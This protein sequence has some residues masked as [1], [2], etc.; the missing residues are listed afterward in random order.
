MTELICHLGALLA[1]VHGA[2]G[3]EVRLGV[4]AV[5]DE[6]AAGRGLEVHHRPAVLHLLRQPPGL[7]LHT[8]DKETME[9]GLDTL[10]RNNR[11][12]KQFPLHLI[13]IYLKIHLTHNIH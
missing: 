11:K 5:L 1:L 12:Q 8:P 3:G 6:E 4:G 9:T 10:D 2:A 7:Q 13:H